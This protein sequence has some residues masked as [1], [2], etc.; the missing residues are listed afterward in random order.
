MASILSLATGATDAIS[1]L[2][3]DNVFASVM[4]GNLVVLG[5]SVGQG[6]AARASHV[7]VAVAG[8]VL[9]VLASSRV[10]GPSDPGRAGWPVRFLLVL[11]AELLVLVAFSTAWAATGGHPSP[12]AQLG[13]L[14]ASSVAMGVQSGAV[15]VLGFTGLPTTYLT[16]TLTTLLADL[17]STGRV[18]WRSLIL[19]GS[20]LVG[21]TVGGVLLVHAPVPAAALPAVFVGV[22]LAAA[23]AVLRPRRATS[24]R[25]GV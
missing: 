1:F 8:F 10:V 12:T 23:L 18:S 14:A 19:L 25:S 3:L 13:M 16:G 7:V 9:G 4:T 17:G 6:D 20:L 11:A 22:G 24:S 15:R 21:A 5:L 2:R